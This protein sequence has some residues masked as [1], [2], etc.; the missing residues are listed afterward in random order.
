VI[1]FDPSALCR[2]FPGLA[3]T[4]DDGRPVVYADA[5]G[6]SQVPD[7]VIDAI[8]GHLRSGISN[9]HGA[10]AASEETDAL[11]AD[12][13]EA[14]ADVTGA[15]AGEIVFGP[16]STTLL[17]HLSRSFGRTLRP[18]DEIVVTRL[19]HDANVR[20]WILAAEDAGAT[21]RWVDIRDEDVT[22][23]LDSFAAA[24]SDR[25]RL[26]AFTLASNAVG[27]VPP[28]A[29]LIDLIHAAGALAAV[30]GVHFAQHRALDLHGLDADILACSPYKFFG[31]HLGILA[32]RRDLLETWMPYKLRPAPDEAPERWETGTQNHEGLAGMTAAIDYLADVGRSF[33]DPAGGS[34][35]AA[36]VAGFGA[37]AAHERELA[38]RFLQGIGDIRSVR[39]WGIANLDRLEER[40]PTFA[41]R[42]GDQEPVKTATELARRGIY[43]WD[44]HYYAITVMER[45]G[46]LDSGGAV[47]IGF[48]HYHSVEDVDRVLSALADLV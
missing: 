31:P 5:P 9:T 32:V 8:A 16:N 26:V 14:A 45:L 15:D 41:I 24:I 28:A 3:R 47:R 38:T 42:V 11:I 19:D 12:A 40:T 35:R 4:G 1:P 18:G 29:Q 30:D 20:P 46:L 7:S 25:T 13:R 27:T 21:I 43:V 2:R 10:F 34:R 36:I 37:I 17:L 22:L 44:G 39:L 48:C 6:G 23:N 33:G